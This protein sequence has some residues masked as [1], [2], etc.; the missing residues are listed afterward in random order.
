VNFSY[1][2]FEDK[3]FVNVNMIKGT[4]KIIRP[5][6][7]AITSAV[8]VFSGLICIGDKL[9]SVKLFAAGVVGFFSAAAG[10]VINDIYDVEID[11]IN[12]PNRPLPGLLITLKQA[13]ILYAFLFASSILLSYLLI[14]HVSIFV[15]LTN[16]LLIL[17]SLSLKKLPLI[18]NIVVAF[19]TGFAF[20]FGGLVVWNV[21][22]AVIPATFAFLINL[23]REVIK[24]MEDKEGDKLAEART[25]PILYSDRTV[26]GFVLMVSTVLFVFTFVP[27][28][29]H[30]YSIDFFLIM[31]IVVNPILFYSVKLM[32][33]DSSKKNLAKISSLL[34][35]NIIIGL[36]AIYLGK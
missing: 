15:L 8:I 6:N 26:K 29:Y 5:L 11:R 2:L 3:Q 7:C 36:I 9:L 34:K 24:D 13:W 14:P 33:L 1:V 32:Y 31:M 20:I 16:I 19:L 25:F 21:R 4:V 17:Y 22:T 12:R 35:L 30:I 10:N 23:I 27:F 28:V 18:G